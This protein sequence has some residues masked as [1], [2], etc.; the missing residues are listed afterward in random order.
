MT[1]SDT[2][3]QPVS[4]ERSRRTGKPL[5]LALECYCK[6]QRRN[7][8]VKVLEIAPWEED[9]SRVTVRALR[10]R[11]ALPGPSELS[12]LMA[13]FSKLWEV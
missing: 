13:L 4:I 5:V 1:A 7:S 9:S 11:S 12:C 8:S 3:S 6:V 10:I 2:V